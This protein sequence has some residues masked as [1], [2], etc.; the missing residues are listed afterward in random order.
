MDAIAV[1]YISVL[2]V[3]ALK[4]AKLDLRLALLGAQE[5]REHLLLDDVLQEERCDER[6]AIVR[7]VWSQT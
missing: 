5:Y 4:A 1:I 6:G 2:N 3:H 7:E